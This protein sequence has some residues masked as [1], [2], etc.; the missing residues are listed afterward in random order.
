MGSAI[1]L[2]DD[3]DG[4]ALRQF[5]KGTRDA[6]QARRLLA[7]AEIYDGG[8]RTDAARIGGVTL[9]IV[10]DWVVR[11][12]EHAFAGLLNGKAPGNRPKLNDDQRQALAKIVERG[13]IP[14]RAMVENG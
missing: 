11:F 14:A 3:F 5:A 8:S 7:L 9:Q 2:R 6:A 4:P 10:R 12:N 1:A 13:P